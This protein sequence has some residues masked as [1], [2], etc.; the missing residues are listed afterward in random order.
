M[1]EKTFS[2]AAALAA[3]ALVAACASEKPQ[4]ETAAAPAGDAAQTD[5]DAIA[6][7][8]DT[9]VGKP[10]AAVDIG[11][12][13]RAAVDAG[14]I[15]VVEFRFSESYLAGSM[16]VRASGSAGLE[17]VPPDPQTTM[18][19]RDK[20]DHRWDISF[21]A[22]A[23]G[24]YYIDLLIAATDASGALETRSYSARVVVGSGGVSPKPG[25][26]T[27]TIDGEPAVVMEAEE[28][29]ID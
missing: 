28:T 11:H 29:V 7:T 12:V 27:E 3:A 9:G 10:G 23:S 24:V 1:A 18:A 25:A 5:P 13:Q 14:E 22:A 6:A 20:A 19:M 8:A 15:G 4:Q 17:I 2:A 21:R 26:R 16:T